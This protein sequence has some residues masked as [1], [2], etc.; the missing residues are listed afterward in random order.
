M[1]R[2][3]YD[4]ATAPFRISIYEENL[5]FFFI[6]VLIWKWP[7][8]LSVPGENERRWRKGDSKLKRSTNIDRLCPRL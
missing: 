1:R 8:N 6:S 3:L 5:I 2:P 7:N 4:F